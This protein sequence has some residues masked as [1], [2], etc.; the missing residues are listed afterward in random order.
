LLNT[1]AKF[2]LTKFVVEIVGG[3]AAQNHQLWRPSFFALTKLGN[4]TQIGVAL[5][6]VAKASREVKKC[7]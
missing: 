3:I 5:P 2:P 1:I 4:A 6:E 7:H